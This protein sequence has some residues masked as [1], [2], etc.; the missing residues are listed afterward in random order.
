MEFE[1]LKLT[2][3]QKIKYKMKRFFR[4]LGRNLKELFTRL[5]VRIKMF[6]ERLGKSIKN[7]FIDLG[8]GIKGLFIALWEKIKRYGQSFWYG[9]AQTKISYLF[10]G[11]GHMGRGQTVRGVFYLLIEVT[12]ILYMVFFGG[13]YLGMFLQN[14]FTGGNVGR[15]ET[16]VSD[17][18]NDELGEYSIIEGDN[19]FLIV[20]YGILS[21]L[22]VGFFAY[23]YFKSVAESF[24]L[25]QCKIIGRKPDGFKKDAGQFLDNKF[26]LTLLSAPM[27]GLLMFTVIPLIT[28]IFI[29]FTNSGVFEFDSSLKFDLIPAIT[30]KLPL[31]IME[32]RRCKMIPSSS[33]RYFGNLGICA[34]GT[35]SIRFILI[36]SG[37]IRRTSHSLPPVIFRTSSRI[38]LRSILKM[39]TFL[40]CRR[41]LAAR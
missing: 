16:H 36:V 34:R 9:N 37:R 30:G 40:I 3:P 23:F 20:L 19:S 2:L 15:T 35:R 11:V 32:Y 41:S 5:G 4:K 21:V 12:F 26:H 8:K 31:G 24:E 22:L 28:M 14:I 13:N 39:L 27:V 29:A 6:F 10:M 7:G 1:E 18:W 25:E 38:F 33:T 17:V